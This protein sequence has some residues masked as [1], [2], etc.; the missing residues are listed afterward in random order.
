MPLTELGHSRQGQDQN[1]G[2]E[3]GKQPHV[4]MENEKFTTSM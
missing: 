3:M 1:G 4:R 2:S